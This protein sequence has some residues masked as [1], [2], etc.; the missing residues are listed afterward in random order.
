MEYL[1]LHILGTKKNI[2]NIYKGCILT[3]FMKEQTPWIK[4]LMEVY[5]KMKKDNSETKLKDAMK[6]AKK[7]YKK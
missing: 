4:H 1:V 5:N 6:E 2:N 7:T 3:I